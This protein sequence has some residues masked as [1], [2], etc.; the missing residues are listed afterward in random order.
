[1]SKLAMLMLGVA[2]TTGTAG[3]GFLI[4]KNQK[5]ESQKLR[6]KYPHALL[7]L[8]SDSS[9]SDK[10]NLLKTK[11]PS[12]P[13]LKQAKTQFSN[14]QQSQ[15]LYKKG[16]NAIYDS[17]GTQYLEDFKTF[18]AKTNKDGITGTWI[19]GGA[20]VNTKWDEKLTNLKK[21]TDKLS[22]RFLEV[23]QSL[24]SDS[25]ND[26]M[27]TNIQK[28]CDNA[29]SEIYLGSESVETRNIKNFCLTSES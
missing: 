14:T 27:R 16:C 15:S 22:S 13:I 11:T 8:D 2:G 18:C 4:A 17:E 6:S 26:E 20:D 9:W 7:T 12:H 23:Q 1:M 24:S 5:D 21:S 3:L 19:K 25:F 10:F 28:A 29:N